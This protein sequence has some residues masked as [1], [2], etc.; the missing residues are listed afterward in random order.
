MNRVSNLERIPR[1]Y[2]DD[3]EFETQLKTVMVGDAIGCERFY[4]NM[5]YVKP[6]AAS[7]KYHSHSKQE[8]LFLIMKGNGILRMDGEEMPVCEGDVVSKP[9]GKDIAHQF[10]NTGSE[11]MQIL[12]VGTR[13][14]DDVATYPAENVVYIRSRKSAFNLGDK[15]EGWSSD[16]NE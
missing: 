16:P 11:V 15:I 3:P 6:G 4:V 9:A 12:D 1:K 13:E 5:D 14:P 7:T 2:M 8:E 10:I